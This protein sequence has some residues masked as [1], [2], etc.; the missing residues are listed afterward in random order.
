MSDEALMFKPGNFKSFHW[1]MLTLGSI[2]GSS[3][4]YTN[5]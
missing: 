3:Y 5:M 4:L 1:E 2:S